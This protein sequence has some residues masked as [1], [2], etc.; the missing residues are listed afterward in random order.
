MSSSPERAGAI[1]YGLNGATTMPLD[2]ATEIQVAGAA[3]FDFVELRAPKIGQF[4][5]TATL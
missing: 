4:L 2:Q 1:K 3:G 5:K